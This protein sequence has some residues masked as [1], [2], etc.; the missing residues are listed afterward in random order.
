MS[1]SSGAGLSRV[2][3]VIVPAHNPDEE[4]LQRTLV[5]LRDQSLP[6]DLW[7][8]IIVDNASSRPLAKEQ[9]PGI[10]PANARVVR[11]PRPGLTYARQCGVRETGG[12][13]LVFVDDDNVLA[14]DYLEYVLRIFT[15]HPRLGAC[16]GR[17]VP[18][19]AAVPPLWVHEFFPLLA[20]R[21]YGDD[22]VI[23]SEGSEGGY[24]TRAAPIGAGMAMRREAMETW[25]NSSP[26][27]ALADR[28]GD[29]LS[30]AGDNDIVLT[31]LAHGWHV[32]YFPEL[33]LTHLI[34][35]TRLVPKYL[36]RL[37]RGIQKSW[38][39]VLTKHGANPWQP[40]AAW[41]VP[42]RASK[43]WFIYRAWSS[44][45]ARIRWHGARGHFEGRVA[46]QR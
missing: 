35:A 46:D 27:S 25:L 8:T 10:A 21:D 34:P 38:M 39:Q 30:S 29:E 37:N 5:A 40:I 17:C 4:R 41:T 9:W 2:L 31:L 45:A 1:G 44:P 11:E 43:A 32:G 6:S 13:F 16:G 19:F 26:A 23:S 7:E 22:P 33:K 15:E 3:S 12:P 14:P 20:L 24:P 28:V 36:E 42:L 18:E